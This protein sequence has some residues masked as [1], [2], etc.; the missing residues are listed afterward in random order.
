MQS[1]KYYHFQTRIRALAARRRTQQTR[2]EDNGIREDIHEDT[3]HE[4]RDSKDNIKPRKS[5]KT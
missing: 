2:R 5:K 1:R 3:K 4:C